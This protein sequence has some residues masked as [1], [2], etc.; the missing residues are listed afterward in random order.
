MNALGIIFADSYSRDERNELTRYRSGASLPV[1]CRF[2]AIDF[3]LSSL[4]D[5]DIRTVGLLTKQ[6]YGSLVDHLNG[7]KY[8]DLA[9]KRGGLSI[10]TPYSRGET[11]VPTATAGKLDA[12]R[13]IVS[14]LKHQSAEYVILAQGNIV[15]NLDLKDILNEHMVSQA[16]ITMVCAN[17][18]NPADRSM[19]PTFD[20]NGLLK[21]VHF[22][23]ESGKH[24]V[25]INCYCM[26]RD[27]LLAFLEKADLYDWHDLNR[28]LI[29]RHMDSL[30]IMGYI[31]KG[32]AAMTG[33]IAQYY[34]CNLD[35]LKA[36]VREDLFNAERP[37]LTHIH[38]TVPT[39]YNFDASVRNTLL[40]DGCE[41]GGTVEN[42]VLFR[43]VVVEKGAQLDNCVIMQGAQIGKN[44]VLKN[45]ICD[46]N[47]VISDGVELI[48]SPAY[49]Y[50]LRKGA[51]V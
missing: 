39:T 16:D 35:M 40:A 9:R 32:Y 27:F 31:H 17:I 37:I 38:D 8:W 30:R 12:L 43:K 41:I 4:V 50:V 21:D 6:N 18:E 20:E 45:V 26:Q 49:P 11:A 29:L 15:T 5:A 1:G 13:G 19:V 36:E 44:A 46:K 24:L 14:Y 23:K 34:K 22:S 25:A 28:D 10:M 33:T 51:K 47:V 48:G 42:S 3:M 7:G 2:R